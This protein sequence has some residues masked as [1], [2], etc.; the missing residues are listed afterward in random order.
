VSSVEPLS[1]SES[2][3]SNGSCGVDGW[4]R[5]MKNEI[6]KRVLGSVSFRDAGKLHT[7]L[8][9][10]TGL[11]PP[12]TRQFVRAALRSAGYTQNKTA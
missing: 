2:L 1:P 7:Q 3:T 11:V 4:S 5:N 8:R 6:V 10:G 9:E 12:Q